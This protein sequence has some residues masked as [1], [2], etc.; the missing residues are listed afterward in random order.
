MSLIAKILP[1]DNVLCGLDAASKERLFEAV[2]Q[3]FENNQQI[4]RKKVLDSLA[5]R[6]KLGSTGLGHGIAIPHGRIKGLREATGAFVK[7]ATPIPFDAPDGQ[8]VGL[9]FILLVPVH[10]TDLHLHIL[11]ELAQMFS[12][13]HLREKLQAS[14]DPTEI[15]RLLTE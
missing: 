4:P 5:A 7:L 10:A 12:G 15:H 8:P 13:R 6:E 3:L 14:H 1:P 11:G 2:G 9:L